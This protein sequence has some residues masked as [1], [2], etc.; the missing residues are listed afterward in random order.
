MT[1]L[2]CFEKGEARNYEHALSKGIVQVVRLA[3]LNQDG[4][5]E[6]KSI[7][8][9]INDDT[10]QNIGICSYTW[11]FDRV[12]WTDKETGLTWEIASRCEDMCKA[13]LKFYPRVWIDGLCM[14]QA[15]P[16]HIADNMKIMGRLYWHGNV[17]PEMVLDKM[18]PEYPLR[19]WVQQEISFT[20]VQYCLT[21][22]QK[23]F[24]DN[25]DIV[26]AFEEYV[27]K[28]KENEG[29]ETES[30]S[31]TFE[32]LPFNKAVND[33]MPFFNVLSRAAEGR[34]SDKAASLQSKIAQLMS[35]LQKASFM[36][37]SFYQ[38]TLVDIL[39]L[40]IPL[41]G[42]LERESNSQGLINGAIQSY[43]TG[44]FRYNTDR[45]VAAFSLA[46]Y[47]SDD[48]EVAEFMAS[49]EKGFVPHQRASITINGNPGRWCTGLNPITNL[50]TI[51]WPT[52][53]EGLLAH[54]YEN[55]KSREELDLFVSILYG[56]AQE[57]V[58][59]KYDYVVGFKRLEEAG[60]HSC[61]F[62]IQQK[63]NATGNVLGLISA[64][65]PIE[66]ENKDD[67]FYASAGHIV[68][69]HIKM[70]LGLRAISLLNSSWHVVSAKDPKMMF[71][72][73]SQTLRMLDLTCAPPFGPFTSPMK[74]AIF[75]FMQALG[76]AA[77]VARNSSNVNEVD[78]SNE[79]WGDENML[80]TEL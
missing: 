46:A 47:V 25:Q 7:D 23:W 30:P 51:K 19:G 73:N 56:C 9:P 3:S 35:N 11:G 37:G 45:Q 60:I 57:H 13:A 2:C 40:D 59:E 62:G 28:R 67:E 48:M 71:P 41:T 5:I 63:Q 14:V 18:A 17:V 34:S 21:P 77:S 72:T 31:V 74:K 43:R 50:E 24:D 44:F 15:W 61:H 32:L 58:K 42:K 78:V 70:E 16:Q 54:D 49:I 27:K 64:N 53:F 8:F 76:C 6:V 52:A 33:S 69:M 36:S 66:I 26:T 38:D 22:L 79:N 68:N 65:I 39:E 29:K 1:Y 4:E 12:D 80:H 75:N 20:N 10:F 55:C